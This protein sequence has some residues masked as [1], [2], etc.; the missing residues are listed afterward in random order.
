MWD[1]RRVHFARVPRGRAGSDAVGPPARLAGLVCRDVQD[2]AAVLA[3]PASF[4]GDP[5]DAFEVIVPSLPGH[6]FSEPVLSLASV[7]TSAPTSC[8]P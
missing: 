8:T 7:P 4:G 5:A 3:D 1:G 2:R 6:G